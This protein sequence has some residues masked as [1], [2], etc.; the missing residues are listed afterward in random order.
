MEKQ[1]EI[2]PL[3]RMNQAELELSDVDL[4]F[5]FEE[6][7]RLEEERRQLEA[8]RQQ[9]QRDADAYYE[10][11][12]GNLQQITD[13]DHPTPELIDSFSALTRLQ[14]EDRAAERNVAY[15]AM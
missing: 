9:Q 8:K 4:A 12:Y 15:E 5:D 3:D 10:A 7:Q 14:R 1:P 2:S 11:R 13:F 6:R